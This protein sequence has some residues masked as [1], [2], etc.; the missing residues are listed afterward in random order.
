MTTAV[1]VIAVWAGQAII[2]WLVIRLRECRYC[3]QTKTELRNLQEHFTTLERQ[4]DRLE[5]ALKVKSLLL[6]SANDRASARRKRRRDSETA[7]HWLARTRKARSKTEK[8]LDMI[9]RRW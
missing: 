1:L 4:R 6:D 8:S 2:T 3:R 5:K 7:I 9:L